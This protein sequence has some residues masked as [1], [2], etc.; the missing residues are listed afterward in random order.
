MCVYKNI[1]IS[2]WHEYTELM[3]RILYSYI[4]L[5]LVIILPGPGFVYTDTGF[6]LNTQ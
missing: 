2:S 6:K 1:V 4:H 3:N 5:I